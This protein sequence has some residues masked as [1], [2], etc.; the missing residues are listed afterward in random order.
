MNRL[1]QILRPQPHSCNTAGAL[2]ILR[3]VVGV[4]FLFH[5]WGKIQNP[6]GW[7]PDGGAMPI[8]GI[9]Q[10]LAAFAEFGGGLALIVGF[11]TPIAAFGM[12]I[13][14]IVAAY[15]HAIV[16]GDPFV[17][18][19]GGSYELPLVFLSIFLLLMATGPGR[20]S[21]DALIFKAKN[22]KG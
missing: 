16:F 5:G 9:F 1:M 20:H 4:A 2:L 15:M 14:M 22:Q 6:F 13:T 7:M 19:G 10:F 3:L 12:A 17:S 21:L 8:P 11:L 18:K